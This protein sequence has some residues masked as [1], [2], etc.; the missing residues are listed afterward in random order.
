M[1]PIGRLI[2]AALLVLVS[3]PS[4]AEDWT[5]KPDLEVQC[6][7]ESCSA[8]DDHGVIPIE[9]SFNARGDFTLC[10]YTGCWQGRGKVLSTSPFLVITKKS[11]DWSD[12]NRR[13][14]GRED[15]L[16]AF[17]PRDGVVMVK[18]GSIAMPMRCSR[19]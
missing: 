13:V 11:V 9:V 6:T 3:V 19:A 14:E 8:S 5:C 16:I 1:N 12:P 18:A 15:V 7:A 4:F 2:H 10:A 17:S